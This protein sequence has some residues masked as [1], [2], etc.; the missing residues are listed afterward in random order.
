MK[1]LLL[2]SCLLSPLMLFG[3]DNLFFTPASVK[4]V[5]VGD[6]YVDTRSDATDATTLYI[7]GDFLA[8]DSSTGTACKIVQE[9]ITKLTGSFFQGSSD[10]VFIRTATEGIN[11]V[12]IFADE[13]GH[14]ASTRYI[15]SKDE[16][17]NFNERSEKFI[18]FPHVVIGTSDLVVLEPRMGMDARTL[19]NTSSAGNIA[20]A[21]TG[22]LRLKSGLYNSKIYDASLR[23]TGLSPSVNGNNAV[24][25]GLVIVERHVAPLRPANNSSAPTATASLGFASP[26]KTLRTG[27]FAGQYVRQMLTA[28]NDHVAY[29]YANSKSSGTTISG[30]HYFRYPDEVLNGG[31]AYLIQLLMGQDATYWDAFEANGGGNGLANGGPGSWP[32]RDNSEDGYWADTYAFDGAP[33]CMTVE[34]E[35]LFADAEIKRTIATASNGSATVNWIIGNSYSAAIDVQKLITKIHNTGSS[36]IKFSNTFYYLPNGATTYVLFTSNTS[37]NTAGKAQLQSGFPLVIPAGGIM[38]L[39]VNK[40][41]SVAGD[42]AITPDLLVHGNSAKNVYDTHSGAGIAHAPAQYAAPAVSSF[43]DEV[44]FRVSPTDNAYWY[45]HA[46]IGIRSG[47]SREKDSQDT[48]KLLNGNDVFQLYSVSDNNSKL[49]ANAVPSEMEPVKLSFKPG[50]NG[51]QFNITASRMESLT[52][53]NGLWIEDLMTGQFTDLLATGGRY[54]FNATPNDPEDRF[55]VHFVSSIPT[56]DPQNPDTGL[57]MPVVWH[58][59]GTVY[60]SNLSEVDLGATL[61]IFD[62][63]GRTIYTGVVSAAPAQQ[64]ALSLTTGIYIARLE[65]AR[66]VTTK[67][68]Y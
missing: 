8:E 26:F 54:T 68:T 46:I 11:G 33:F 47:S 24:T 40:A 25:A 3:A 39:R 23:I 6:M 63:Q 37:D 62:A 10:S 19:K 66:S 5:N 31:Q 28:A 58:K 56:P 18:A 49:S 42:F 29:P 48:D 35:Q 50:A 21:A 13:S 51:G 22:K 55:L 41:N 43:I 64:I 17:S 44:L 57:E 4:M 1:K 7:K 61:S 45:D 14:S 27:Y 36:G 20:T 2:L 67:F 9:G 60:L 38:M 34:S 32:K 53:G 52:V 15:T 59:N 12:F 65:G 30:A 16:Q